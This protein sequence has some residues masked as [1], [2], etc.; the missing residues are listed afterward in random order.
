MIPYPAID[1]V[2]FTAGPIQVHWYGLMYVLA[3]CGAW[4]LGRVRCKASDGRWNDEE[5][6]DLIFYGALGVIL[7]GRLGLCA[8][9]RLVPVCRKPAV[10]GAH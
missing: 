3:F 5:L 8:L 1:P 9:L 4:L 7:G 10:A 6:G 2:I